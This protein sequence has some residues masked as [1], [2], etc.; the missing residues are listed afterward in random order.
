M[1]L[2]KHIENFEKLLTEE[3]T[4]IS[5]KVTGH[6]GRGGSKG[7]DVDDIFAGGFIATDSLKGDLTR[8]FN[9]RLTQRKELDLD[10]EHAPPFGGYHDIET[11][12]LLATYEYWDEILQAKIKY[13]DEMTPES[14]INWKLIDPRNWKKI[15][16][17]RAELA[18]IKRE[19]GKDFINYSRK[20]YQKVG[21]EYQYDDEKIEEKNKENEK[22]IN[23]TDDWK[24]IYDKKKY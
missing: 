19:R 3:T 17:R 13:N 4:G 23:D 8:Q 12:E 1:K 6:H 22:F 21:I 20:S 14:D 16:Q 10:D 5:A 2:K 11:D 18:A 9:K 7:K 24:S 15:L